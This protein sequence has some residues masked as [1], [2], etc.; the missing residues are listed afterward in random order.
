MPET[1]R[2]HVRLHSPVSVGERV[3]DLVMPLEFLEGSALYEVTNDD[4]VV[5]EDGNPCDGTA[6]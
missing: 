5:N 1:E 4:V 6:P 2:P 3:H